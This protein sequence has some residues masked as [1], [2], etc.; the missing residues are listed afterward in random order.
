[1]EMMEAEG[2]ERL[3]IPLLC[4]WAAVLQAAGSRQQ[5]GC[6]AGTWQRPLAQSLGDERRALCATL[7]G[8]APGPPAGGWWV[9]LSVPVS[10]RS[11]CEAFSMAPG[12]GEHSAKV[13]RS[14]CALEPPPGRPCT[15]SVPVPSQLWP[16][17]EA[18]LMF[19]CIN[20]WL[21][22]SADGRG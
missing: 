1:M 17:V 7:G 20:F 21:F 2:E 14:A 3:L 8:G 13:S 10:L 6:R 5:A 12:R 15:P 4:C 22:F 11:L 18:R 16:L 9:G 19:S